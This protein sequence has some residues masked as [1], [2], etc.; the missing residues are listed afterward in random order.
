M[1]SSETNEQAATNTRLAFSRFARAST[2]LG[3][4][5]VVLGSAVLYSGWRSR[6]PGTVR[7]GQLVFSILFLCLFANTLC[8]LVGVIASG[9]ALTQPKN[10][11]DGL[12]VVWLIVSAILLALSLGVWSWSGLAI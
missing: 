10:G 11:R 5:P 4:L 9:A 12:P 3:L 7:C 6:V 1:S 8:E 2:L